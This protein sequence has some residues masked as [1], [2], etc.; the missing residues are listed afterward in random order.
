MW[1]GEE[2]GGDFDSVEC[3]IGLGRLIA[4]VP[5]GQEG[6]VKATSEGQGGL[7]EIGRGGPGNIHGG[8]SFIMGPSNNFEIR[9]RCG[10]PRS[11]F[12]PWMEALNLVLLCD[13]V[14]QMN[15]GGWTINN[16]E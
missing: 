14:W 13:Y 16:G 8:F 2:G 9:A 12:R 5:A 3:A 4:I 11:P 1:R 6:F 10:W 7:S 15:Q